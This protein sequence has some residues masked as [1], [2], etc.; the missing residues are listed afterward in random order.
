MTFSHLIQ[1]VNLTRRFGDVVAVNGLEL[2][3]PQGA[4]YS[5]LG[6]NGAGKTTT[7]RMLLGLIRP[8]DGDVRLFDQSLRANKR[9]VLRRIGAMV[10]GPSLYPHLTGR[11][12]VELTRRLIDATV[13]QRD[14]ALHI[15]RLTDA[16]D[17]LV[18]TYSSG[19][20]QRLGWRWL[21]SP[22]GILILDGRPT[23]STRRVTRCVVS[24]AA[25]RRKGSPLP[26]AI[27]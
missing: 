16:A 1:T 13:A 22:I 14:R 27:C 21:C 8:T 24:L 18:K 2:A 6:P 5:F 3:V 19:M 26:P 25:T 11:E 15:V 20:K 23:A 4:V 17:R 12:N 7:I 9:D 10:E